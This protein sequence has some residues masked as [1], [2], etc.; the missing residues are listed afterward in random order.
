MIFRYCSCF[1]N[2]CYAEMLFHSSTSRI[3]PFVVLHVNL[4]FF[5]G[6]SDWMQHV[7]HSPQSTPKRWQKKLS[8]KWWAHMNE[9]FELQRWMR[10]V[11]CV[12]LKKT[13]APDVL[14]RRRW[15]AAKKIGGRSWESFGLVQELLSYTDL[16]QSWERFDS[17]L[18]RKLL[19]FTKLWRVWS[20]WS[21]WSLRNNILL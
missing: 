11:S 3:E 12:S 17:L 14:R 20:C 10:A 13:L 9:L 5:K 16:R 19:R 18:G 21:R 8:R 2:Q 15:A 4:S 6:L 1:L 7:L